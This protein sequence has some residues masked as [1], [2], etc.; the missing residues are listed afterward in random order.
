MKIY[1]D[2]NEIP[3]ANFMECL[4]GK[5][6]FMYKNNFFDIKYSDY[7]KIDK[8][9]DKFLDIL[10]Q[11]EDINIQIPRISYLI[12]LNYSKHITE[13]NMKY[14]EKA[15]SLKVE[16][17]RLTKSNGKYKFL[18]EVSTL[19]IFMKKEIDIYKVS[20]AKYFAYRKKYIA[21]TETK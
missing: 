1:R 18:D 15:E 20:A 12:A 4:E 16:Y 17:E 19:E 3:I 2:I 11:K 6:Q 8:L 10:D 5:Y 14:L 7:K 21:Y 13:G 9:S